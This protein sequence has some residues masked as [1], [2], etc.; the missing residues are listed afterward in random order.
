MVKNVFMSGIDERGE[1][2]LKF[3]IFHVHLEGLMIHQSKIYRSGNQ[4]LNP[5]IFKVVMNL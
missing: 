5:Y 3:L 1:K 2:N 4:K